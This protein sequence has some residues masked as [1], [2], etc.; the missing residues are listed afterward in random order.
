MNE[1]ILY[2]ILLAVD[3]RESL[4]LTVFLICIF[5]IPLIFICIYDVI[6]Y[7]FGNDCHKCKYGK[8]AGEHPIWY[9]DKT[10]DVIPKKGKCLCKSYERR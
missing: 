5:L 2:M 4:V 6:I 1:V 3:N 10:Y 9:C 8:L 7:L